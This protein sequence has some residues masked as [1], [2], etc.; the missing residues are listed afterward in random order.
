MAWTVAAV[1]KL[2]DKTKAQFSV[3]S[4]NKIKDVAAA[5]RISTTIQ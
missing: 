4:E 5:L 3:Y 2:G 1:K